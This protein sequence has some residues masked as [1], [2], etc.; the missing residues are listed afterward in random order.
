MNTSNLQFSGLKLMHST[1]PQTRS[2]DNTFIRVIKLEEADE[3]R[4]P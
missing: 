3:D 4:K 2:L 1:S